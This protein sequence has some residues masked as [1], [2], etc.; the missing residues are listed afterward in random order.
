MNFS[1][2]CLEELKNGIISRQWSET[3]CHY[4]DKST[5][6]KGQ[7]AFE[8]SEE[9]KSKAKSRYKIESENSELKHMHGV[10]RSHICESVW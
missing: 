8:N 9:F 5:E 3:P 10:R 6:N 2:S 4:G 7:K 1:K